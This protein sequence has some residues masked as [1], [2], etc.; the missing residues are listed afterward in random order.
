MLANYWRHHPYE[1]TLSGQHMVVVVVAGWK[2]ST[3]Y[4]S[5][6]AVGLEYRRDFAAANFL[7]ECDTGAV[8]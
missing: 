5:L 4:Q 1:A 8:Q 6:C 7:H 2:D 3:P